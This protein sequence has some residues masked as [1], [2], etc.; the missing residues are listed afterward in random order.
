MPLCAFQNDYLAMGVTPIE[1]IFIEHYLPH[2]PGDYVRVYL[3]GLMQCYHPG[4]DMALPKLAQ[5]LGL[6]ESAVANAFQ[7]W[8]R[9]GLLRRVSDNP[10]SYEYLNLAAA[11]GGESPM[12]QAAYRHRDFNTRLQQLFDK[13][14][15]HPAEFM[16]ACEWVE[17][18]HLP[19][20]VVLIMVEHFVRT[21]GRS[22]QF[23]QLEKTAL[24]WAEQGV[25]TP[26]AARDMLLRD[27]AAYKLAQKVLDRFNLRRAPT[28][29]EADLA[30]KWLE[31]WRL[32][33]EAVLVACRETVKGRNPSFGYLDGILSRNQ[34]AR[35]SEDMAGR[36]DETERLREAVKA[37]H[38]ALGIQQMAPT[39]AEIDLYRNFI[40]AGFSPESVRR[41]ARSMGDSGSYSMENLNRQM[42]RF[43]EMGLMT[44]MQIG[45]YLD[46]QKLLRE[47]AARVYEKCGLEKRV[48]AASAAQMEEWLDMGSF[49]MV[50]FAA[51]CARDAKM[52][53][54]YISK[55]LREWKKAGFTT[56]EEARRQHEALRGAAPDARK[57]AP[58]AQPFEQR[59][60]TQEQ[61]AALTDADFA[62]YVE[63]DKHD[64]S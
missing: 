21:K 5:L 44:D 54:Q 40:A 38:E 51:E 61:L 1:N 59:A 49:P 53:P 33:E 42:T 58:A 25:N 46:R 18:L 48:N 52:P 32:T 19:E 20:E 63:E 57:G 28:K 64:P 50:L 24:Q 30:R 34:S 47:Q 23:K 12:E 22:F 27:S 56:V 15:L 55:L 39:P 37:I 3:Y 45:E 2:A 62:K 36:L 29:E 16:A 14:L 6:E 26:E 11:L 13:R 43:V 35:T 31:D 8:E 7:Y 9:Q 17:D 41:V 4:S 10:P 60:Y